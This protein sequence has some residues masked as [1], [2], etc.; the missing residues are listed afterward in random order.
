MLFALPGR[1]RLGGGRRRSGHRG[2]AGTA[3]STPRR[4]ARRAGRRADSRC[5]WASSAPATTRRRCCCRT[6]PSATTSR[7]ASVVTTS[8]LSGGER[9]RKFGFA[10]ASTDLDAVLADAGRRRGVRRDPAQLARRAD[11]AGAARGQGRVRREAAGAVRGG[12]GEVLD[13]IAESGNDRL[14][15]GFNRR[16]APLLARGQGSSSAAGSAR[17][18]SATWST[19]A[20]STH[21]S[22]YNQRR[23]PRAPGSPARAGTSSTRSSWLLD[24]DPVSVYATR[25]ARP[26]RPA[27]RCCA[28]RTARPRSITYATTGVAR[29]PEGD[30][31]PARPTA[32]C[33][34]STTSPRAVGARPQEVGHAADPARPRQGPARRARRV[35]DAVRTGGADAGPASTRWPPPRWPRCRRTTSLATGA[36]V[37]VRRATAPDGA[38]ADGRPAGTCAG[39]PGWGRAE[40]PAGR[41][42]R[43]RCAAGGGVSTRAGRGRPGRRDR[44]FAAPCPP[45][46]AG[47]RVRPTRP[48][49][50]LATADRLMDGHAE[51][52][53]VGARRPGRDPDWSLDPKTGR[54]APAD[55]YAFDIALPRR[56]RGRRHQAAVGALAPPAPDR[57]GRRVRG[58]RRRALRAPGRRPPAV[59]VGGEP[60]AARACTGSAASSWASGC[61]RGCGCAGC[62]TA[63]RA[64]PTCSRTTP[65]RCTR[66]GTTSAGWPRF[67]QPRLVGQQPRDRR[68]RRAAGGRARAFAWF[69][70]SPR[71]RTAALRSLDDAAAAQ[72]VRLRAQPRAGH[73]V[74]R[75]GAGAGPRRGRG[76]R[77]RRASRCPSRPG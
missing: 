34:G 12:A 6:W 39:C 42:R 30:A 16:F 10:D 11:R 56:G 54:R 31:R 27:G 41:R 59:V 69:P 64:P 32:R 13:A 36:P 58:D 26:A 70:E 20:R 23:Q 74:P 17:P 53:G 2:R 51:Y 63:G 67:A 77:R 44:R 7:C 38:R 46:C 65:R 18:P 19:R 22:W 62:S 52:F 72:H 43:R 33:C 76:G 55:V 1:R 3:P 28:T 45:G 61:C 21:G 4:A 29:L 49:R 48:T 15:V 68:G 66:S 73:R 35:P 8:A 37:P 14:Q 47:R 24:A 50:L 25:H 40:S 9:Q 5:G 60:A 75:A 71:W 57:A